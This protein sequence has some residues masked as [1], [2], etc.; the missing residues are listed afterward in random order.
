MARPAALLVTTRATRKRKP[1]DPWGDQS[2]TVLGGLWPRRLNRTRQRV[3]QTVNGLLDGFLLALRAGGRAPLTIDWY[4]ARLGRL[5]AALGDTPLDKIT[6][7]ELRAFLVSVAQGS[8]GSPRR[9]SYVDGFRIAAAAFFA[10]CVREG[11]LARSPAAGVARVKSRPREIRV[12]TDEEIDK[13]IS[14]Q[15]HRTPLGIRN[16]V[17]IAM[18]YDTGVRVGELVTLRLSDLDLAS[19]YATVRGKTGEGRVPLSFELRRALLTYIQRARPHLDRGSDLVFVG[20]RGEHLLPSAV[21]LMLRR[22]GRAAGIEKV[23]GPHLF[24]H[25]FSTAYLRGGGD[26]YTL[27]RILR[28]RTAAMTQRYVH[29]VHSDVEERHRAASPLT[30]LGARVV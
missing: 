26:P 8:G 23:V 21:N 27:Q 30:R 24:R 9:P 3:R 5:A 11:Y 6:A 1:L 28:H 7:D 2:T 10:W 25:S 4:T 22:G 14:I 17:M 18:L 12:L 29:L 13:L 15:P 16:R 20:R 19:G